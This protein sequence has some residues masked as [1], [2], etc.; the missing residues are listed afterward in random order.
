MALDTAEK[1]ELVG[2]VATELKLIQEKST[3][4]RAEDKGI[5]EGLKTSFA[6]H[7]K[8]LQDS[9]EAIKSLSD[10]KEKQEKENEELKSR[11]GVAEKHIAKGGASEEKKL[12]NNELLSKWFRGKESEMDSV[13]GHLEFYK[14]ISH[15]KYNGKDLDTKTLTTTNAAAVLTTSVGGLLHRLEW[16]SPVRQYANVKTTDKEN[17]KV[18]ILDL[19][20]ETNNAAYLAATAVLPSATQSYSTAATLNP[21]KVGRRW[22]IDYAVMDSSDFNLEAEGMKE[23]MIRIMKVEGAAFCVGDGT[24]FTPKGFLDDLKDRK[25]T[26]T[27]TGRNVRAFDTAAKG[28]ITIAELQKLKAQVNPGYLDPAWYCNSETIGYIATLTSGGTTGFP[29]L[30]Y[31][32]QEA[33]PMKILGKS[34]RLLEDMPSSSDTTGATTRDNTLVYGSLMDGY[35]I[36]DRGPTRI[37]RDMFTQAA[38]GIVWVNLFRFNDGQVVN[39]DALALLRS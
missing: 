26:S 3:S 37:I 38:E 10:A 11:L 4:D 18:P 8:T 21:E 19:R 32:A 15:E 28:V 25:A 22:S 24:G 27:I 35:C 23:N 39:A 20:N 14:G 16:M 13:K 29:V 30:Q 12:S 6:A 5:V 9:A 33:T 2:V 7:V 17:L 34:V 1:Q 31:S 36:V